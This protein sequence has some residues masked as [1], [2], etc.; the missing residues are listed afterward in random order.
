VHQP[1]N[2]GPDVV[3][4]SG[5][6]AWAQVGE[7]IAK[8]WANVKTLAQ[9]TIQAGEK[10][11]VNPI[12]MNTLGNAPGGH[13]RLIADWLQPLASPKS[14]GAFPSDRPGMPPLPPSSSL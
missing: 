1:D 14:S 11:E 7:Q 8:A 6:A 10:D 13:S 2:D 9:N 12:Y 3:P 5:D 4:V